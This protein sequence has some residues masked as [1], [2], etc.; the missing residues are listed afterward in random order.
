[1]LFGESKKK[2]YQW[3]TTKPSR[4]VNNVVLITKNSYKVGRM[5]EEL[6]LAG[7]QVGQKT[8]ASWYTAGRSYGPLSSHQRDKKLRLPWK[9]NKYAPR[10]A[11]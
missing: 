1:M 7:K 6:N 11:T 2:K 10:F 3:E 4:I 5:L 9:R 8:K